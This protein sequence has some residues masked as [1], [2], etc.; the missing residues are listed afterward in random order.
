MSVP[1]PEPGIRLIRRDS[2]DEFDGQMNLFQH[3]LSFAVVELDRHYG[4]LRL[5][6]QQRLGELF[7]PRDYPATLTGMFSVDHDYP[8]VEPPRYLEQLN[9]ELYEQ[10]CRRIQ[11]RFNEAVTLAESAFIDEFAKLID[12]LSDRLAGD[13]DG[14]PK[15][16]RDSAVT[17]LNEFFDRFRMLN[18]RSNQ[19]LDQLV[20]D[21]QSIVGGIDPQTLRTNGAVRTNVAEQMVEIQ[22]SLDQLLVERPRRNILRRPR[23]GE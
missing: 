12:H 16:F 9:P 21:A 22:E 1:F 8:A 7:D 17:N 14:K 10:E 2:I 13:D 5:A 18:I 6:A 11:S 19:Q 4:E 23:N 20:N 3:E 15:I